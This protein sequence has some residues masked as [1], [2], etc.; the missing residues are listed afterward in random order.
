MPVIA[1]SRFRGIQGDIQPMLPFRRQ[2]T[3]VALEQLLPLSGKRL[4]DTF[5]M[6]PRHVLGVA[7]AHRDAIEPTQ[8]HPR[9]L[10]GQLAADQ[11]DR[12]L[13]GQT[14]AA[15]FQTQGLFA[16]VVGGLARSAT[17]VRAAVR[18]RPQHRHHLPRP[19]PFKP[20][21]LSARARPVAALLLAVALRQ[22]FGQHFA[23]HGSTEFDHPFF[24]LCRR[25][26]ICHDRLPHLLGKIQDLLLKLSWKVP[27]IV[28]PNIHLAT[29]LGPW[30]YATCPFWW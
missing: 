19:I 25:T 23:P 2:V 26:A 28:W 15:A 16:S 21:L 7:N 6:H 18:H 12:F 17:V 9:P 10:E 29:L 20:L 24:G 3:Q 1:K 22:T 27:L 30:R 13:S 8:K 5:A 11:G 14:E 4:L